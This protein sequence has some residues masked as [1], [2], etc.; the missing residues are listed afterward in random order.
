MRQEIFVR[1]CRDYLRD[2]I[3]FI[4]Y[5]HWGGFCILRTDP[6]ELTRPDGH[7]QPRTKVHQIGPRA[8]QSWEKNLLKLRRRGA[9]VITVNYDGKT[10]TIEGGTLDL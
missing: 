6:V 2:K 7:G 10:V 9:H 3:P 4:A 5:C 8:F 1:R